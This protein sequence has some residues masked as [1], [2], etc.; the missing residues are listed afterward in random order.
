[1]KTKQITL[2]EENFRSLMN[3]GIVIMT[4]GMRNNG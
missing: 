4:K 3:T 2:T 1:M